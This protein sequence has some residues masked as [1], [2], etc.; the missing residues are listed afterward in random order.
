MPEID[1]LE[2]NLRQAD[3]A[4]ARDDR[5]RYA[6]LVH[7]FHDLLIV[8]ADNRKLEAHYRMLMNQLAYPRLV[9]TSLS[10]PGRR[11]PTASTTTC[12]T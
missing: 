9:T 2:E 1:R 5:D 8:G 12:W 10:Q 3:M 4:V 6:E 11:S 7:E